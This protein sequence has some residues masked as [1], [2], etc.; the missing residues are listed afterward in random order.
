MCCQISG[1]ALQGQYNDS[2]RLRV[3]KTDGTQKILSLA[4]TNLH[5]FVSSQIHMKDLHQLKTSPEYS[6]PTASA[7]LEF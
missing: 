7:V 1:V 3:I 6:H 2:E 4:F 5:S